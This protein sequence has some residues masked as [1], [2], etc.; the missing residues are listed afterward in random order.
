MSGKGKRGLGNI[1]KLPSG[2]YQLRYTDP[3]G[4]PQSGGTFGTKA[5]AEMEL[6]RIQGSIERGTYHQAK[7]IKEGDT[8]PKTLTLMELGELWRAQRLN[9][10]G[11]PLSPNTLAGYE[12]DVRVVLQ[13]L[14]TKRVREITSGLVAKWWKDNAPQARTT[15]T[16]K[17][18]IVGGRNRN[19]AYKHLNTLMRYAIKQGWIV[20]NPCDIEGANVYVPDE[21][22]AVPDIK[23]V[24]IMLR[25]AP[26]P[27][28][29]LIELAAWGGF[30]KG[31]LLE[32]RRKDIDHVK[33]DDGTTWLE[34]N[35]NRAVV[36]DKT[37][38]IVRVPKT[39]GSKRK[40]S[41]PQRCNE[42]VLRYLNTIPINPDA[43][44]FSSS[45]IENTHWAEGTLDKRWRRI[46]ALAGYEG[47]FHSLRGFAATQYGLTGATAIEIMSRFGHRNIKTAM[48]YQ[49]TTGRENHLLKLIG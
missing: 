48:R 33:D 6:N 21:Q 40:V 42:G 19:A 25:E 45:S 35:V 2:R 24:E 3:F 10:R 18:R 43:L 46:R 9:P 11:Q 14:S 28:R 22:P 39:T 26:E 32:L 8:D 38:A 23:H 47:T 15:K 41:L 1:R 37:K 20:E 7:A 31:E 13:P 34:V 17:T 29:T 27:M 49:R 36:W 5:L 30:R 4:L 16:G 44:L 12:R